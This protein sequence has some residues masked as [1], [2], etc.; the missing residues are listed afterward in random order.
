MSRAPFQLAQLDTAHDRMA[1]DSDS[2]PLN[3]YLHEQVSQD[4]RR[5][6][7]ACFVALENGQRIAG[8]DSLASPSILLTDL[9]ASTGKK[10]PHYPSV[11]AVRMDR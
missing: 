9:P 2:E 5:C 3:R 8:Y 4:V 7:A 6:I 1:F 11:P 10:L